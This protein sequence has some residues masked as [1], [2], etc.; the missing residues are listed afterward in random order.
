MQNTVSVASDVH[1]N[2]VGLP[3]SITLENSTGFG[4]RLVGMMVKQ[5]QGSIAIERGGGT[6]FVIRAGL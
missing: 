5:I 2:G 3:E 6:K 1:E 4:M